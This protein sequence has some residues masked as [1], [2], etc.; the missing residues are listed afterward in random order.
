MVMH[1]TE[2]INKWWKS[3]V[4]IWFLVDFFLSPLN[5]NFSVCEHCGQID[6]AY[7]LLAFVPFFFS[8][9]AKSS[10]CICVCVYEFSYVVQTIIEIGWNEMKTER[11]TVIERKSKQDIGIDL[12]RVQKAIG[13][14]ATL[15]TNLIRLVS[16]RSFVASSS[17]FLCFSITATIT[18][19][20][21]IQ[22][23]H[24]FNTLLLQ[25]AIIRF[26]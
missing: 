15:A 2:I 7:E 14:A 5:L 25:E 1:N 26:R 3:M 13:N 16:Y 22:Y 19:L 20:F 8:P 12:K 4:I 23:F 24:L 6:S 21:A 18:A 9:K 17:H 10:M 11:Q